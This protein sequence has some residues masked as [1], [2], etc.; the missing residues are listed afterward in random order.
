MSNKRN[1]EERFSVWNK[2]VMDEKYALISHAIQLGE[3]AEAQKYKDVLIKNGINP[4]EFPS[5]KEFNRQNDI[6]LE[7]INSNVQRS[8]CIKRKLLTICRIILIWNYC[9]SS[10]FAIIPYRNYSA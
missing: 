4:N 6:T 3:T 2:C 9:L 1:Y 7:Y 10:A 5:A 8:S